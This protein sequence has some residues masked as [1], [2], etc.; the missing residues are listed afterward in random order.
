[1]K[2]FVSLA[3]IFLFAFNFVFP[4][5]IYAQNPA[6][7]PVTTQETPPSDSSGDEESDTYSDYLLWIIA[8]VIILI[9]FIIALG[10]SAG[11]RHRA[12]S[13]HTSTTKVKNTDS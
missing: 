5:A 10:L 7:S 2:K 8:A 4:T 6:S 13:V 9:L 12:D 1:M 11:D 3:M